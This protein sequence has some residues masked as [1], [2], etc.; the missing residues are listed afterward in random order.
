[1]NANIISNLVQKSQNVFLK[2]TKNIF[3]EKFE[4]LYLYYVCV[5]VYSKMNYNL[6]SKQNIDIM[7]IQ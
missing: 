6:K 4:N 3:K 2:T 5:Y 7:S 1:M